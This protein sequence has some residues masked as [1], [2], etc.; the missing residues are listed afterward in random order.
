MDILVHADGFRLHDGLRD[1]VAE[2]I[3]RVEQYAPRALRARVHLH[4]I[5]A[6]ASNK[7]FRVNVLVEIPGDDVS[8]EEFGPEPLAALDLLAEKVEQRLRKV[9]TAKL[10][11]RTRTAKRDKV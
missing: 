2:K 5:S 3:G 7:Q 9:K 1:A 10:A 6:H 11:K 4:K 8:A